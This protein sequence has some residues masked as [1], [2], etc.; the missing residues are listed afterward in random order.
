MAIGSVKLI[1]SVA[2]AAKFDALDNALKHN[3]KLMAI[4]G[5]FMRFQTLKR[6]AKGV[7]VNDLTFVPYSKPYA[8]KRKAAGLPIGKVDLF[9]TGSMLASMT[10]VPQDGVVRLYFMDT[11]DKFGKRNPQKAFFNQTFGARSRRSRQF[12]AISLT[13]IVAIEKIVKTYIN[14]YLK[15]TVRSGGK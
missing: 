8:K 9:W 1:G 10:Y 15:K 2:I 4:I 13:D 6:T 12:F 14:K 7:D 11:T 3:K 5:N